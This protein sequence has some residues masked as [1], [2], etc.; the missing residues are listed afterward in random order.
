MIKLHIPAS[1]MPTRKTL[2]YNQ[3]EEAVRNKIGILR[4]TLENFI[5]RTI[6]TGGHNA[7]SLNPVGYKVMKIIDPVAAPKKR[8]D[9]K[10]YIDATKDF[11]R[12]A[13]MM[14]STSVPDLKIVIALLY[15]LELKKDLL[16]DLLLCPP[17]ELQSF[18]NNLI[19]SYKIVPANHFS[20][21]KLAF[22]YELFE[23]EITQY[24][25]KFYWTPVK[26]LTYKYCPYCNLEDITPDVMPNGS[27]KNIGTLDHFFNKENYPLLNYSMFNLVPSCNECNM[28][29][30]KNINFDNDY[31]LN[32]HFS[33]MNYHMYFIPIYKGDIRKIDNIDIKYNQA[34]TLKETQQLIGDSKLGNANELGNL[35][36]FNI[37]NRYEKVGIEKIKVRL[38]RIHATNKNIPYLG[39]LISRMFRKPDPELYREW[40]AKNMESHFDE[41]DFGKSMFS[42]LYRDI[43]N[44]YYNEIDYSSINNFIRELKDKEND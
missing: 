29:Y 23:K 37:L 7:G 13:R 25:K 9:A 33:G 43:H 18:N 19:S 40:Y 34:N 30:K 39:K 28:A 44:F 32:P 11:K 17:D 3:I 41:K 22:D 20:F 15:D 14:I 35:T 38:E 16:S 42:K 10:K 36:V 1:E 12:K 27:F 4:T 31:H 24:I 2:Y 21:L 26:S 5:Q 6:K 8:P